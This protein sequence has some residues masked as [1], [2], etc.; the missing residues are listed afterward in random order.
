MNAAIRLLQQLH[1]YSAP[2]NDGTDGGTGAAGGGENAGENAGDSGDQKSG[3]MLSND[4]YKQFQAML[5]NSSED[6]SKSNSG[7]SA[8][9]RLK[10]SDKTENDQK[11]M[12][13][14]IRENVLFDNGFNAFI[15]TNKTL[16]NMTAEKMRTGADGLDGQDL[17]DE[18]S[19]IAV[20]DFFSKVEN[21][22]FLDAADQEKAKAI[23]KQHDKFI[24]GGEAW[25]LIKTAVNVASKTTRHSE[26][27]NAGGSGGVDTPNIDAYIAKCKEQGKKAG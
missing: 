24:D 23:L 1:G 12:A 2:E 26:F 27:K 7:A 22:E 14:D 15:D 3:V 25:Q 4:E 6:K 5:N 17:T 21:I 16:F 13:S 9:D 20:K 8:Y 19:K 11:K 10:D 18:L